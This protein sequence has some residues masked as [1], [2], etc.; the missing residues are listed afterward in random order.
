MEG[1]NW[2]WGLAINDLI[3]VGI[4]FLLAFPIGWERSHSARSL[5]LR[6]FP[7]VAV[8]SCA[9]ML[10]AIRTPGAT[11]ESINRVLQGLLSGIGFI[12]LRFN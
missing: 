6:T 8:A 10:I 3:H 12:E 7:L 5:G 9:Y 1:F 2:N 11:P 4:A